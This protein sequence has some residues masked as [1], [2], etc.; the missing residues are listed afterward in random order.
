MIRLTPFFHKCVLLALSFA[1]IR[2]LSR[3]D[4]ALFFVP[5]YA[6]ANYLVIFALLKSGWVRN[7]WARWAPVAVNVA[8]FLVLQ[9]LNL[10]G[11]LSATNQ[12][13]PQTTAVLMGF[14][15]YFLQMLGLMIGILG[16]KI[17]LP[18]FL[19]F[20]LATV[21]FPKFLSGPIES[22]DFV[23]RVKTYRYRWNSRNLDQGITYMMVGAVFKYLIADHLKHLVTLTEVQSPLGILRSAT[24]FEFQVYFDFCGYSLMAYGAAIIVGLPILL[25]FDH[26]F[27]AKDVPEF[28]R[29]W[30]IG[31][32]R[33]F[34]SFVFEPLRDLFPGKHWRRIALPLLVFSLS[35]LWHGQS[36]N[37]FVWGL[38]HGISFAA[39]V[40]VNERVRVGV[41]ASRVHLFLTLIMGRLLF[42]DAD[43][44]RLLQ[45][46]KTLFSFSAWKADLEKFGQIVAS[47]WALLPQA[48]QGGFLI[49][50]G[51]LVVGISIWDAEKEKRRPLYGLFGSDLAFVCALIIFFA[52]LPV[53]RETN[54][55]Y[56][57]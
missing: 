38:F 52:L 19:D 24:A 37:F 25:N 43:S 51:L 5:A 10:I 36:L 13:Q 49:G 3:K 11:I 42:M 23:E 7:T 53:T 39:Y 27:G 20:L 22:L 48:Q 46:V 40:F 16:G 30:H 35:A 15:F 29:R 6:L 50:L 55:V 56:G 4:A 57:R 17:A 33:W 8:A 47:S 14:A 45:K 2:W 26:P 9:K 41:F 54:F 44:P 12:V 21:Y 18:G 1:F 32:G 34:H 28:W 31:L